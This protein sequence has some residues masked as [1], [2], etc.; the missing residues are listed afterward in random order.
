VFSTSTGTPAVALQLP[1]TRL[2]SSPGRSRP[3]RRSPSRPAA[4]RQPAHRER[5]CQPQG[6]NGPDGTRLRA[7]RA[8]LPAL[9]CRTSARSG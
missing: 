5:G 9:I 6:A 2:A 3:E 7:C 8:D 1:P 4:H